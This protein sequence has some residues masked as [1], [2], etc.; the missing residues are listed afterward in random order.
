MVLAMGLMSSVSAPA[1]PIG[2]AG[3]PMPASQGP[4]EGQGSPGLPGRQAVDPAP[5]AT[6]A[7]L[8]AGPQGFYDVDAQLTAVAAR[9]ASLPPGPRRRIGVQIR[10]IRTEEA[11]QRAR[12]GGEL[13]DWA[14]ESMTQK[15]DQLVQQYPSLRGD[16]G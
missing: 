14:R 6:G 5:G 8:G 15:L 12:H 11:T 9:V 1:Q 7:Y 10:Q 2:D 13:L 4:P 3:A 16:A